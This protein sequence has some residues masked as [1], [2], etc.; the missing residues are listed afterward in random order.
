M[1]TVPP[2]EDNNGIL[3]SHYQ[4]VN[5]CCLAP[6]VCQCLAAGRWFSPNTLDSSTNKTDRHDIAEILLKVALNI[7]TT[8]IIL[9]AV[10]KY[11]SF[12]ML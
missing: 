11:Y 2:G 3:V 9:C 5:G 6:K 4:R 7:T 1:R 12:E 8:T 10:I